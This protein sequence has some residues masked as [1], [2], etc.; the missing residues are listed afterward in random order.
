MM[1]EFFSADIELSV[2]NKIIL[3]I[4]LNL[5]VTEHFAGDIGLPKNYKYGMGNY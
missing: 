4:T 5:F 2:W 1:V 3:I